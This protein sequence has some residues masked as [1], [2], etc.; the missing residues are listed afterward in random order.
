[1]DAYKLSRRSSRPGVALM[2][3]NVPDEGISSVGWVTTGWELEG[4]GEKG[5]WWRCH[6]GGSALQTNQDW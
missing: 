1:M 5:G 3:S 2:R 4:Q 6:H